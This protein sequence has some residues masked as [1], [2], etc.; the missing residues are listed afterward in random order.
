M[1]QV[2]RVAFQFLLLDVRN[3]WDYPALTALVK[4]A[5]IKPQYHL[6]MKA[7]N[8]VQTCRKSSRPGESTS[9][10]GQVAVKYSWKMLTIQST[11]NDRWDSL[12]PIS[13]RR[14]W[15]EGIYTE[16]EPYRGEKTSDGDVPRWV[17]IV[18]FL[19]KIGFFEQFW[20]SYE[21]WHMSAHSRVLFPLE[22]NYQQVSI[23]SQWPP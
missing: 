3:P 22:H 8:A 2:C 23:C 5:L 11:F 15:G 1:K 19:W 4:T 7:K 21:L 13:P 12:S 18:V 17:R 14:R 16:K 9:G 20:S 6:S 10:C